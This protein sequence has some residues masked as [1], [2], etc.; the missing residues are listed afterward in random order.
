MGSN[1]PSLFPML[2]LWAIVLFCLFTY[3]HATATRGEESVE[4]IAR[5][6]SLVDHHGL[7]SLK[8]RPTEGLPEARAELDAHAV[9]SAD[10]ARQASC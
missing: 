6:L 8:G 9:E 5:A 2:R 1:H 10:Q 3:I 7:R 4:K